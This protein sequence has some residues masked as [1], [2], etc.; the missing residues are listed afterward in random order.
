MTWRS[1]RR[2]ATL[3]N[4]FRSQPLTMKS[5]RITALLILV[6]APAPSYR[7]RTT[8]WEPASSPG[9]EST[10]PRLGELSGDRSV[11]S[12]VPSMALVAQPSWSHRGWQCAKRLTMHQQSYA[13]ELTA[14]KTVQ[15]NTNGQS[16]LMQKPP[17]HLQ[18]ICARIVHGIMSKNVLMCAETHLKIILPEGSLFNPTLWDFCV[19]TFHDRESQHGWIVKQRRYERTTVTRQQSKSDASFRVHLGPEGFRGHAFA[20]CLCPENGDS[21]T[22]QTW[23][24]HAFTVCNLERRH[25]QL[26]LQYLKYLSRLQREDL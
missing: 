2:C 20:V 8:V 9:V 24:G 25:T 21:S 10:E 19:S 18:E 16:Q 7:A 4:L 26:R 22:L 14:D 5:V 15:Q 3:H 23:V 1:L 6:M 13:K 12:G 17:W 11:R